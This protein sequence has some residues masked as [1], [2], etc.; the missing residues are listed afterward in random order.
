[1]RRAWRA[2]F[3]DVVGIVDDVS[4]VGSGAAGQAP[5]GSEFER[6]MK[7]DIRL[8]EICSD[9]LRFDSA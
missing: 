9:S 3:D 7:L 4:R 2:D 8:N 6:G 5:D 1:M